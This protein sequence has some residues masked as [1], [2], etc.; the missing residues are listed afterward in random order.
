MTF[1]QLA[2]FIYFRL[3]KFLKPMADRMI[4]LYWAEPVD[5]KEYFYEIL[6]I[7]KQVLTF[8]RLFWKPKNIYQYYFEGQFTVE[9][10]KKNKFVLQHF[11]KQFLIETM[12][13]WH[14]LKA[15]ENNSNKIW[16][17][18]SKFSEVVLDIGANTGIYSLITASVNTKATIHAFEPVQRIFKKLVYN[19]EINHFSVHCHEFAL[20]DQD[21][22]ATIYD[23]PDRHLYSLSINKNIAY[24]A[25]SLLPTQIPI[26]RLDTFIE[27][28]KITKIDLI[29]IDVETHEPEVLRGMGKYLALWKPTILVEIL[30]NEVGKQVEQ[31][32]SG[33]D[34]LFF[35]IDDNKIEPVKSL[36]PD[37]QFCNYLLCDREIAK[38]IGL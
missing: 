9:I 36:S 16:I 11:G 37:E 7:K 13:F 4:W 21:G 28:N 6:P 33:I 18:L 10:D 2:K 8:F 23:M 24:K 38:K 15:W 5:R 20:S 29:K 32:I 19:T 31:E 35:K 1:K 25:D 27:K 3:P 30:N 14:G 17:E 22:L 34:Y 26:L 12:L